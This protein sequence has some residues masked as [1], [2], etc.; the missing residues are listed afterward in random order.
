MGFIDWEFLGKGLQSTGQNISGLLMD[1]YMRQKAEEEN[2]RNMKREHDYRMTEFDAKQTRTKADMLDIETKLIKVK[3]DQEKLDYT[4]KTQV[5]TFFGSPEFTAHIKNGLTSP[6]PIM[7][8]ATMA[9]V[10]VINK[11]RSNTP[12]TAED[13]KALAAIQDPSVSAGMAGLRQQNAQTNMQMKYMEAQS[14]YLKALQMQASIKG[15]TRGFT[16][17]DILAIEK[18]IVDNDV[19]INTLMQDKEFM[20]ISG[21]ADDIQ[22][23]M[24]GQPPEVIQQALMQELNTT[25][26]GIYQNAIMTMESIRQQN[27]E[28]RQRVSMMKGVV[29]IPGMPQLQPRP[30]P[31]PKPE[32]VAEE[33]GS[34]I[35]DILGQVFNVAKGKA[36]FQKEQQIRIAKKKYQLPT[37]AKVRIFDNAEEEDAFRRSPGAV[38]TYILVTSGEEKGLWKLIKNEKG[39]VGFQKVL[40]K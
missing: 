31:G 28:L 2:V 40:K 36:G 23:K 35:Q 25:N 7:K 8:V 19:R 17:N 18:T 20:A 16:D 39:T 27:E 1:Q 12:L 4:Y 38:G 32:P 15:N 22:K 6:D 34:G 29:G 33:K 14:G 5:D 9:Q 3:S 26:F 30:S 13:E 10:N 11:L 21:K 24:Q 37:D